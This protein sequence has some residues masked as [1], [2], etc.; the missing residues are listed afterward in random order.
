MHCC[1]VHTQGQSADADLLQ[2]R[3]AEAHLDCSLC[4]AHK[5][6]LL[7]ERSEGDCLWR[8]LDSVLHQPQVLACPRH[9]CMELKQVCQLPY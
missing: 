5:G 4:K 7:L 1:V 9:A 6:I 3:Q 2:S 8:Q